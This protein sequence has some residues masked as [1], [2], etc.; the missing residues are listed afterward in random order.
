MIPLSDCNAFWEATTSYHI[1]AMSRLVQTCSATGLVSGPILTV[2]F[3]VEDETRSAVWARWTGLVARGPLVGPGE[4][5]M[6]GTGGGSMSPC[7]LE[8][9]G[10]DREV[11]G[12]GS[13]ELRLGVG[14]IGLGPR[15]AVVGAGD[16]REAGESSSVDAYLA[17]RAGGSPPECG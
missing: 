11:R 1:S 2:D 12:G 14:V 3:G 9:G 5:R 15:V 4:D 8:G 13:T 7:F 10:T 16:N 17:R 6:D